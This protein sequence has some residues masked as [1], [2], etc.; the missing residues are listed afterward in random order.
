MHMLLGMKTVKRSYWVKKGQKPISW[1]EPNSAKRFKDV[2]QTNIS[3]SSIHLKN[4]TRGKNS[5][6]KRFKNF[7]CKQTYCICFL[8]RA[9]TILLGFVKCNH[10][11]GTNINKT[12]AC[13]CSVILG[14]THAPLHREKGSL[15]HASLTTPLKTGSSLRN[16][17]WAI[18]Y[19]RT[20]SILSCW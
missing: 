4:I 8:H 13:I 11:I 5:N 3:P 2:S 16:V 14:L 9:H 17:R 20:K 12:K 18:H 15:I 19:E 1:F 7:Q 10:Q 6:Y